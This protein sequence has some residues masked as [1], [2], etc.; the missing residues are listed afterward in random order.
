MLPAFSARTCSSSRSAASDDLEVLDDRVGLVLAVEGVLV[1]ALHRVLG[2]V[3]DLAQ[4]GRQVRPLQLGE[5]VGHQHR[6][7][8][9]LGHADVEERARLLALAHLDDAALLVEGDV[10]EAAHGDRQ[11]GVLAPLGGRDD[12][13]GHADQLLLDGAGALAFFSRHGALT[14]FF[15]R[16][17]LRAGRGPSPTA[18]RVLPRSV[19]GARAR[20]PPRA[21]RRGRAFLVQAFRDAASASRRPRLRGWRAARTRRPPGSAG[22]SPFGPFRRDDDRVGQALRAAAVVPRISSVRAPPVRFA[23]IFWSCSLSFS[24]GSLPP[25]R[26]PQASTTSSMYSSKML[27]RRNSLLARSRRRRNTPS[28]RPHSWSA[29]LISFRISS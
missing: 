21:G 28:R 17:G 23:A 29:S 25:F 4:R 16:F 11:R 12:R 7:H 8:E 14:P 18:A 9:L 27:R 13:V 20:L 5:R 24:F 26:R 6:L 2:A 10:G 1:R 22:A 15:A 19:I 3:V